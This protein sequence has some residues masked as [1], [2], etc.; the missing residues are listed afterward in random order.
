MSLGNCLSSLLPLERFPNRSFNTNSAG[1]AMRLPFGPALF[2]EIVQQAFHRRFV[3]FNDQP[4]E[5][6]QH[7]VVQNP[8]SGFVYSPQVADDR[9]AVRATARATG[10]PGPCFGIEPRAV[11]AALARARR[12]CLWSAKARLRFSK[13]SEPPTGLRLPRTCPAY[14]G[15]PSTAGGPRFRSRGTSRRSAARTALPAAA[16]RPTYR[17]AIAAPWPEWR[18]A[19]PRPGW[20]RGCRDPGRCLAWRT[21]SNT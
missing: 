12:S 7:A 5:D 19:A 9:R 16:R 11:P 15:G 18:S 20:R 21:G 3:E 14:G 8:G 13:H 1:S 4:F 10:L 2:V 17:S 6:R